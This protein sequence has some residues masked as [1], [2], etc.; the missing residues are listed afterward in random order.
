MEVKKKQT[1]IF[2]CIHRSNKSSSQKRAFTDYEDKTVELS[3][4]NKKKTK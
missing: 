3:A 4:T 2:L 1:E